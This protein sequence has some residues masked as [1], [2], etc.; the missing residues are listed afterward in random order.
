MHNNV[1]YDIV[2]DLCTHRLDWKIHS[3]VEFKKK[4]LQSHIQGLFP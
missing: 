1:K 2:S 3:D 4:L